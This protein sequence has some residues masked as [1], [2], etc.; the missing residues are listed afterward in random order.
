MIE[1]MKATN[2]EIERRFNAGEI[3]F[4]AFDGWLRWIWGV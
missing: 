4:E 1:E 2:R 3:T